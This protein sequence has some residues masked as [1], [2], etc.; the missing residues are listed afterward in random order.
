MALVG[1]KNFFNQRLIKI[2]ILVIVVLAAT[3]ALGYFLFSKEKVDLGTSGTNGKGKEQRVARL[4][5]GV[6]VD[7]GRENFYPVA[8]MIENLSTIRPQSG[9]NKANVV[10]ETLAEGGITRFLAIYASGEKIEEIGP[11]RSARD[12]YLDWVSEYNALYAHVGGSPS[13]LRL[14][15]QYSLLD[16]DQIGGDHPYFWRDRER[17]TAFE[18][19]LF[20]SSELQARALRDKKIQKEGD[21]EPWLFK[22]EEA[23]LSERPDE[24]KKITIDFSTYSYKVEYEYN[25]EKN[26]YLRSNGGTPHLDFKTQEQL[27]AKNVVVQYVKTRLVDSSRLAI[28]AIGEGGA[29]VFQ[30]GQMIN[31]TW[32]KESRAERTRFYNK[33]GKEIQ[34]NPGPTWVE[35]VPTDR[36]VEYN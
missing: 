21:Y 31:A 25:R 10:Y 33:D 8:I 7:K 13:A 3:V 11:V 15:T 29:L 19:T 28:E 26:V 6:L 4:I 16:L 24:A 22:K 35:I 23:S 18:H 36:E 34:F 17:A 32:K 27:L 20:T 12:Y 2:T 30:D 14:I 1:L 9:L 5:D